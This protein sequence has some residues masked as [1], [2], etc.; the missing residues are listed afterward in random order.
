M[1]LLS[2]RR[3]FH[4]NLFL[5]WLLQH[6]IIAI[7]TCGLKDNLAHRVGNPARKNCPNIQA[8]F[9]HISSA[10]ITK[11][12]LSSTAPEA[13]SQPIDGRAAQHWGQ[14]AH[15]EGKTCSYGRSFTN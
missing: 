10:G 5:L 8:I 3:V 1:Y 9:A 6:Y 13:V 7:F 11:N 15:L 12:D 2:S 14:T 4:M